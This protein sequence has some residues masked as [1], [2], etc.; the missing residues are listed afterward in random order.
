MHKIPPGSCESAYNP[1]MNFQK[2]TKSHIELP[3]IKMRFCAFSEDPRGI[4]CIYGSYMWDFVHFWKFLMG[5][6]AFLEDPGGV[7]CI[8]GSSSWDFAHFWKILVGFF[9]FL[10]ITWHPSAVNFS[11]FNLLL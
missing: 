10:V 7:L 11:H 5:F 4:L 8:F 3:E 2:G 9:A 1:M 6:C